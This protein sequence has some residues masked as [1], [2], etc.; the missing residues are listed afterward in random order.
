MT[1]W[2]HSSWLALDPEVAGQECRR[3]GPAVDDVP[4]GSVA[5]PDREVGVTAP[6]VLEHFGVRTVAAVYLQEYV[7]RAVDDVGFY[8]GEQVLNLLREALA[9]A[10]VDRLGQL[11]QRQIREAARHAVGDPLQHALEQ[12]T[13]RR[14]RQR[15]LLDGEVDAPGEVE[16]DARREV[17]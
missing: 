4:P 17:V 15:Q 10:F 11:R 14:L 12:V 1:Y 6:G 8:L 7:Q 5:P 16:A 13:D 3:R 9:G 2:S